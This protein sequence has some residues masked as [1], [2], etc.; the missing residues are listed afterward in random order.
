M[1]RN[2]PW[3]VDVRAPWERPGSKWRFL[4]PLYFWRVTVYNRRY[5]WFWVPASM[6]TWRYR[7]FLED[8]DSVCLRAFKSHGALT[9]RE[10]TDWLNREDLL[11]T[12]P[13]RTGIYKIS[14]ATAHDWINL[15]RRRGYVTAWVNDPSGPQG[16]RRVGF[17]W[18]LTERGRGAVRSRFM[19]FISRFPYTPSITLLV[20]GGGIAALNSVLNWLSVHQAMLVAVYYGLLLVL[21]VSAGLFVAASLEKRETPGEAVVA[22][23]TLRSAGKS[24]PAL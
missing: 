16:K 11:R 1:K 3:L 12:E 17:H 20:A 19:S 4:M 2:E 10:L 23:E 9:P 7:R 18:K 13:D 14:V 22:I 15:A 5:G 24:I 8:L 6:D 21:S